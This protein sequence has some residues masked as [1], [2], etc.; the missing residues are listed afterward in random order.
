MTWTVMWARRNSWPCTDVAFQMRP[1]L[2]PASFSTSC[3][4]WC[5]TRPSRAVSPSK[6]PYRSSTFAMVVNALMTRF[7]PS[8]GKYLIYERWQTLNREEEKNPDGSEKEITYGEYVDK[9]NRRALEEQKKI[10]QAKMKGQ[11]KNK[12]ND[13]PW[14]SKLFVRGGRRVRCQMKFVRQSIR[15]HRWG[16]VSHSTVMTLLL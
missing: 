4:S 3:S 1:D 10:M 12:D 2:S 6:R 5:T 15:Y 9:I 14:R 13:E 11:L 7:V 8:S 16:W